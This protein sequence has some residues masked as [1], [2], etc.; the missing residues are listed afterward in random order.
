MSKLS[1]AQLKAAFA[2]PKQEE[3]DFGNSNFY[4]FYNMKANEK[5]VVR[6]LSDKN[7]DNPRGFLV[8]KVFHVLTINGQKRNVPCLSMYDEDCPICAVSAEYYKNKDEANGKKY[9]KKKQYLAQALVVEDPLPADAKTN[10]KHLGNVRILALGYQLYNI[11]KEAFGSDDLEAAPY[12]NQ[13][14]YDFTIKKTMQGEYPT[15]VVG[16]KFANKSRSLSE[17]ELMVTDE[18]SVDLVTTLPRNPGAEKVQAMLNAD[19]SGTSY[20]SE[21]DANSPPTDKSTTESKSVDT[22]KKSTPTAKPTKAATPAPDA[23]ANKN[24]GTDASNVEAVLAAIR[25][26]A[27]HNKTK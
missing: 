24:D 7:P 2:T 23:P 25:A 27:Q 12:D 11:I 17:E 14:G 19:M 9:W 21:D 16:T 6:F 1:I 15:Y 22:E 4:P 10:V 8:E 18:Q 20:D 26:R 5:A 3:R 13:D